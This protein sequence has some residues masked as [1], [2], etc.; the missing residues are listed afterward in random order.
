MVVNALYVGSLINDLAL[1]MIPVLIRQTT[2]LIVHLKRFYLIFNLPLLI[3][4]KRLDIA[5]IFTIPAIVK[6]FA[7]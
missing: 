3:E 7:V 5:I 2:S 1:M 6:R 4:N